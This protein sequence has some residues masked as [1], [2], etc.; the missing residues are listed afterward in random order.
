MYGS[1][2]PPAPDVGCGGLIPHEMG[3]LWG[4]NPP[5]LKKCL[6]L[7]RSWIHYEVVFFP[8]GE[9]SEEDDNEAKD[10][11]MVKYLTRVVGVQGIPNSSFYS[12][13]HRAL[14]EQYVRFCFQK[15]TM[16]INKCRWSC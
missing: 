11:R 2:S 4:K 16:E 10:M 7:S 1:M 8:T 15:V 6:K 9:I 14:G 3:S 5:N 12:P 13:Q